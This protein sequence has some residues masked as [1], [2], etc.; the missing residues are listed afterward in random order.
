VDLAL[1]NC[2]KAN[3]EFELSC[4]LRTPENSYLHIKSLWKGALAVLFLKKK[5]R[6]KKEI[7]K[8]KKTMRLKRRSLPG[9]KLSE[10]RLAWR[11]LPR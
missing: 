10:R 9:R 3:R 6:N 11:Q 4:K 2:S 7:K 5:K 8:K 1:L